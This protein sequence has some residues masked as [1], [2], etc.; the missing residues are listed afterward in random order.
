MKCPYPDCAG[1]NDPDDAFCGECGRSLEPEVVSTY[2]REL[3]AE[4]IPTDEANETINLQPAPRPVPLPGPVP[5]PVPGPIPTPK[6]KPEGNRMPLI[7][8]GVGALVLLTL[9]AGFAL[10]RGSNN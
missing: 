10:S 1:E 8:G 5:G 3:Q 6:S 4:Q 7:L 9:I 2:L